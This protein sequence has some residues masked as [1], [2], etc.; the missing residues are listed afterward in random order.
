MIKLI[1]RIRGGFVDTLGLFIPSAEWVY[2]HGEYSSELIEYLEWHHLPGGLTAK[3]PLSR[4]RFLQDG[5]GLSIL[6][7]LRADVKWDY[8]YCKLLDVWEYRRSTLDIPSLED[9]HVIS[10]SSD[11]VE[12]KGKPR[13]VVTSTEGWIPRG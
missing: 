7:E 6:R 9:W 8:R 5:D 4:E 11:W 10:L 13:F 12:F 2:F 1:K 3:L